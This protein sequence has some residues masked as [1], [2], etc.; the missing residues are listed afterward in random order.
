LLANDAVWIV[1]RFVDQ[2]ED[3][4]VRTLERAPVR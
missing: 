3:L 2:T 4:S 1:N